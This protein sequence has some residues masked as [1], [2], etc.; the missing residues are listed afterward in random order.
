MTPKEI[1]QLIEEKDIKFIDLRFMD[2]IGL[3]Q[4][5]SYPAHA[6]TLDVFEEGMGFD[7]SSMRGWQAI[8]NSDMILLPDPT[9]AKIDPFAAV[10]TLILIC[11]VFDPITKEPYTRDPRHIA[12]KSINYM[13][14][15]GIADTAFFGPEAEFFIFDNVRYGYNA[16]SG[17]F[18]FDSV[19]GDWNSGSKQDGQNL[20][21]KIRHK[22]GYFPVPPHDTLMDIRAEMCLLMEQ[23][24]ITVEAHHHEVATG[25]QCEIDVKYAPMVEQADNMQLYKYVVKNV[26]R[27]HGKTV[28]FM[29]KPMYGDNGSGMHCHQSLWKDGKPLF[30]GDEYAGLSELGLYYIGGIIKHAKAIAAFTNPTTNSYKRLVP[31]YE[32]P[33]NLAYSSRN[34]S[35]ALRIPMY[36]NSPKAKRV[37]VR[38]PDPSCNPYLAFTAMLMAGLDGIENKIDPGEPMDKNLYD[39][40]PIELLNVP[41]MPKSLDEALDALEKDHEFLLKGDVFT[42]D[43]ISTWISYKRENECAPV[44]MRVHPYEFKLYY[45]C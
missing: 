39:L 34:R 40:D 43:V 45:D 1:L 16:N 33:V 28:T 7:G 35:A 11:N 23:L 8:N 32:A 36:S 38:F 14:G 19:E 41:Q 2:F 31:G 26:A 3:W 10:P 29:P 15:T 9:T 20:G 25:G 42:E 24:G 44:N 5:C 4:H 13:K 17:F 22:E 18:F 37:E 27:M 12:K 30:A 21:Y 6:L